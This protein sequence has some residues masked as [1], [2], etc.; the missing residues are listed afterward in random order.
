MSR[1]KSKTI[2]MQAHKSC[3]GLSLRFLECIT[4]RHPEYITAQLRIIYSEGFMMVE[5]R[6]LL[7]PNRAQ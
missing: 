1:P 6:I 2:N 7:G 4:F 5:P 3:P